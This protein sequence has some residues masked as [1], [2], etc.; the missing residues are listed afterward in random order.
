MDRRLSFNALLRTFCDN[1]YF[2]P[3]ENLRMKFPAL[4]YEPDY[5][6]REHA[7]NKAYTL[8]DRYLLTVIDPDPDSELRHK[9]RMLP[10][11]VFIR[12][13]QT[14]GLNHF[15]YSLYY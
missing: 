15:N 7:D 1:V 9:V 6:H 8:V 5:E 13:F 12:S 3:P 14:E 2:Q 4:V 10:M 11:C